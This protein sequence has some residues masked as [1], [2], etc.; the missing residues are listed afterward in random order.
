MHY[1][2]IQI[3]L[4]DLP[5]FTADGIIPG[6]TGALRATDALMVC[7]D[8]AADDLLDQAEVC[9]RV[10][11]SR[12]LVPDWEEAPEGGQA[13][14]MLTVGTKVDVPA[15][16]DNL[17]I[18]REL[19]PE[20]PEI[21]P[22]SVENGSGLDELRARCF[23]ILDIVR[24]YSKQPGK[25]PDMDQPFTLRRGSTVLDLAREIHRE[26][27]EHLNFARIW[28]SGKFDGQTVQRDHA[29]VDGD[30]IEIHV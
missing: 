9:L 26:M 10:M 28:G 22:A 8:L 14:P 15:A 30:V 21:V 27:A 25:P 12:G 3:Q 7:L 2:D 11:A 5:P 29:L 16:A 6:M 17:K 1:E 24:V 13:K 4:V 18:L 20:L 19:K 23:R